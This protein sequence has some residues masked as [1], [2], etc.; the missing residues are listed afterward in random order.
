M[1]KHQPVV[2]ATFIYDSTILNPENI[3]LG[4]TPEWLLVEPIWI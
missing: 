4:T 1:A 2:V 3:P